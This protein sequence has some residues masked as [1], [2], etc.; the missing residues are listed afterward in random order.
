MNRENFQAGGGPRGGLR[1]HALRAVLLGA[2]AA[3]P[4]V[5]HAPSAAAQGAAAAVTG[6]G[7]AELVPQY[8]RTTL[9]N[10]LTL[11][12]LEQHE[13]PIVNFEMAFRA[14]S[15]ADPAG[16]EGLADVTMAMLRK[17]TNQ[18]TSEQLSEELDFLGA[19]LDLGAA[20]ER[21][22]LQA[23]CLSKDTDAGLGLIAEL[24]LRPK[25]DATELQKLISLNLD[26]LRELK[27]TPRQ[28]VAQYYDAYLFGSHPFARPVG[29]TEKSLPKITRDDVVG[30]AQTHLRPNNAILVVV[31]DF[32]AD[33]MRGKIESA[34]GSWPRGDAKPVAEAAPK[35]VK[36]RRVL[37]VDKPDATQSYFRIGNVGVAKGNPD[38]PALD[39]V[40]TVFG[41][42]FTSWLMTELRTKSGLSYNAHAAFVQR[43]VPG[44]FY[45]S[46]FTRVDD[47]QKAID[48]AL[49]IL[50]RLHTKGLSDTELESAKN[51]IRGQFPPDYESPGQLAAAI[52]DLEFFGLD[53]AYVNDHTRRTDAVTAADAK[54]A[55][56]LHYPRKDLTTV[57]V[58]QAAKVRKFVGKYGIVSEKSISAPGF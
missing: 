16:K 27:D 3:V 1:R 51:Y 49:T 33:A 47:T 7:A 25:F 39:V 54:R 4:V 19:E 18:Y 53:R 48:L 34:L 24:L 23:Q 40:N 36:G 35:T 50:E 6:A 55:I 26:G 17:G 31:G 44:A 56:G 38:D 10:G 11:L 14:G 8:V 46:S 57:V 9:A 41:G 42:R 43:R 22:S 32:S 30:Y 15:I 21:C 2:M 29:G 52:A 5:L 20:H 28:V 12:L 45:I 37:L 13:V 58:G